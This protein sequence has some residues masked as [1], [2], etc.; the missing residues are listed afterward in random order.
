MSLNQKAAGDSEYEIRKMALL[1]AYGEVS[2]SHHAIDDF[3]MKLL[4]YL[5]LA[6]LVGVFL[7]DVDNLIARE[8]ANSVSSELIGFAA[9]FALSLTLALFSY[10]IRGI[11]RCHNL[12]VEGQHIEDQL[13][14]GHGQFHVCAEEHK[15]PSAVAKVL[16]AKL[17]ACT[18]YS[19]VFA[20]WLFIA[21]R[22]G[23]GIGTLTCSVCAVVVGLLI[24]LATFLAVRKLT[25]P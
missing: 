17:A 3:R 23:F 12:I 8:P 16:N 20:G 5:P 15:D 22:F 21:L 2:K 11:R 13:G 24:T 9:M 25:A 18:I 7:L 1:A 19:L 10:E 4:G 14:I 6:S